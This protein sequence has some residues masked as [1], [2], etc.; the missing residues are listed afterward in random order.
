MK[1][2]KIIAYIGGIIQIVG[3]VLSIYG[4][5]KSSS[6][7]NY[8]LFIS[9]IT[10]TPL[11]LLNFMAGFSVLFTKS[12]R[13]VLLLIINYLLQILQFKFKGVYYFY[14]LGPYLG[15]G[16][17]KKVNQNISFWWDGSEYIFT[18]LIRFVDDK[19]GYFL[20]FNIVALF[21]LFVL[22]QEY[23]NRKANVRK[24]EN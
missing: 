7:P 1:T 23:R 2:V 24:M 14:A 3:G 5:Y 10:V 22:L 11:I 8:E 17:V 4:L 13:G 6:N 9:L 12:P 21:F 18:T 19:I 15:F 20:T 16:F